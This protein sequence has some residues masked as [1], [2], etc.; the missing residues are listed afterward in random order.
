MKVI[1]VWQPFSS[2]LVKGFKIFET[3][4]WAPPASVIGTTIGIASTKNLI[5][6]QRQAF[7]DENFQFFYRDLDMPA[8]ETLPMGYLLGTVTLDSYELVTEEFLDDI[9]PE[10]RAYGWF[11]LG[12]YAWRCTNAHELKHPIPIRGAQGFFDYRGFDHGTQN[13]DPEDRRQ[14]RPEDLRAHLSLC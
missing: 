2:L 7:A 13:Q 5:S 8:F 12:G 1:S 10:E 3:R 14:T 9:T 4:T 11:K 6:A